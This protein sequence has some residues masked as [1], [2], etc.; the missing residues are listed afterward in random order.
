[1]CWQISEGIASNV[2]NVGTSS[3]SARTR[4]ETMKITTMETEAAAAVAYRDSL[5]LAITVE[6]GGI[7]MPIVGTEK[8]TRT[9]AHPIIAQELNRSNRT[10]NLKARPIKEISRRPQEQS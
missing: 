8:R 1:M 5:A 9:D 10:I 6:R 3:I 4:I 7:D 2:S